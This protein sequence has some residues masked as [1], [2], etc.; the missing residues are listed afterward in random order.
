[1]QAWDSFFQNRFWVG[2]S[3]NSGLFSE[4]VGLEKHAFS[5]V[6]LQSK[7]NVKE[8]QSILQPQCMYITT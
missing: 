2:G 3:S 6:M 1:M 8:Y 7:R 4:K 5:R